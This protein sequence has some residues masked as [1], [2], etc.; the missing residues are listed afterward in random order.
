MKEGGGTDDK[1]KDINPDE[2]EVEIDLSSNI[3]EE[4]PQ[5]HE[6]SSNIGMSH[7]KLKPQRPDGFQPENDM[8]QGASAANT[9]SDAKNHDEFGSSSAEFK[10]HF[11]FG[12]TCV[13]IRRSINLIGAIA[14]LLNVALDIVYAYKVSFQLKLMYILMCVFLAVRLFFALGFGQY[15]YSKFVRNYRA[16]LGGLAE[17]KFSDDQVVADER[18]RSTSRKQAEIKNHGQTLYSSLHLLYYTGFYRILPSSD[19]KYE[20]AVGYSMELFLTTIPMLFC[21]LFNNSSTDGKLKGVQSAALLMKLFS[22]TILIIELF[23]LIWEVK[24]NYDMKKLGI[25][26]PKLTEEQR[27]TRYAKKMSIVAITSMVLFLIVLIAGNFAN[28]S[29]ECGDKQALEQ[30]VCVDCEDENCLDCSGMGSKQCSKCAVGYVLNSQGKCIDCDDKEY[31]ECLECSAKD[32][33]ALSHECTSCAT[34]HRLTDG[35]CVLC[36]ADNSC[37]AC[38][39]DECITCTDG[40]RLQSGQCIPCLDSLH[41]CKRCGNAEICD[42]CD[43]NI[44]KLDVNG[45]C[46]VC[47]LGWKPAT[48]TTEKNCQCDDFVDVLG[49]NKCSKC[50]D[51]I[52]GCD[53]CEQVEQPG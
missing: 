37:D 1:D 7:H 31:V 18:N 8:F 32:E 35:K 21:Q 5:V 42:V 6:R 50:Y 16:N 33:L 40:T 48:D 26:I 41:H 46:K 14:A 9:A 25:G 44:A 19:F 17:E 36:N 27:R 49:G 28:K 22:L 52:P 24:K 11:Y 15:Y 23:L 38:T 29:R 39:I 2:V 43:S 3:N 13:N 45:Q 47:I 34:G 4:E 53:V 10:K 12:T 30:A 20:L 51:L